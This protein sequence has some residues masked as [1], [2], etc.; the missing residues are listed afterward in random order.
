MSS[1]PSEQS[2]SDK[3]ADSSYRWGG[4]LLVTLI[5]GVI[6]TFTGLWFYSAIWSADKANPET[7]KQAAEKAEK[8]CVLMGGGYDRCKQLVGQHHNRC[9]TEHLVTGD[10]GD[11]SLD[12]EGY[13]ECME[14]A[15]ERENVGS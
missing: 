1:T 2:Q 15:F 9:R 4:G 14:S 12:S 11:Q 7:I 10:T 6:L 8:Q 5:L 3:P 13:I